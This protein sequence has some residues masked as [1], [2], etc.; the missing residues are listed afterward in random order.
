[1]SEKQ[2]ETQNEKRQR[3]SVLNFGN[4]GDGVNGHRMN[5]KDR[6]GKPR[7]WNFQP[8]QQAPDE[9]CAQ[10]VQCHIHSVVA[11]RILS[12][13]QPLQPQGERGERKIRLEPNSQRSQFSGHQRIF[14]F[15]QTMVVY[16]ETSG[17]DWQ[18]NDEN[19]NR[20]QERAKYEAKPAFAAQAGIRKIGF[21]APVIV[22]FCRRRRDWVVAVHWVCDRQ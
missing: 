16:D 3:E 18:V 17:E 21:A 20:D 22:C 12:P 6:R 7:A 10:G 4:S 1:V 5:S 9:K 15:D 11:S 13:R 8:H 14:F 19:Q 2:P